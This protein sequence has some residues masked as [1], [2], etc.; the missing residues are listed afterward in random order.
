MAERRN[1]LLALGRRALE[2]HAADRRLDGFERLGTR[3][4]REQPLALFGPRIAVERGKERG[5]KV[6]ALERTVLAR[7]AALRLLIL[8]RTLRVGERE[9]GAESRSQLGKRQ[10]PSSVVHID[11][12]DRAVAH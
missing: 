9:S 7:R 11:G 5:I 10:R 8:E 4:V 12:D 2:A 6:R 3:R 1:L